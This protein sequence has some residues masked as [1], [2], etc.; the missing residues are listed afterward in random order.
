ML[1]TLY[2]RAPNK[3]FHVAKQYYWWRVPYNDE[4]AE[5]DSL[6]A[7]MLCP[8]C[9]KNMPRLQIRNNH[10][11]PGTK[12]QYPVPEELFRKGAT[13]K[14][15]KRMRFEDPW[16]LRDHLARQSPTMP[17]DPMLNGDTTTTQLLAQFHAR[18]SL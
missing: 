11:C 5:E 2:E 9:G 7:T 17:M 16:M 6:P 12:T 15:T 14:A 4:V 18:R 10:Q 13:Y 8:G 3:K 1:I